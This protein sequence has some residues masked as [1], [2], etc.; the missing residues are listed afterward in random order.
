MTKKTLLLVLV[1][2]LTCSLF[3]FDGNRK[4]FLLGIGAGLSHTNF[5]QELEFLGNTEKSHTMNETGFATDFKI[6]YAPNNRLELYVTNKIAWFNFSEAFDE[7]IIANDVTCLGL[8]YFLSSELDDNTWHPSAF[9][10]GGLGVSS[11]SAPLDDEDNDN[12]TDEAE[13]TG[14]FIGVGYEFSKHFR[15]SLNYFINNPEYE[16]S[17]LKLTTNTNAF[18]L[19]VSGLAF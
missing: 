14:A 16:N 13:G 7:V 2:T 5:Q 15:V 3:A 18:M 11:W 6:G 10:S 9:V 12:T 17:I 8:S 19:T 1:L 4:G